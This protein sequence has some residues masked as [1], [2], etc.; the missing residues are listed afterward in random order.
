MTNLSTVS[1]SEAAIAP[2]TLRVLIV[3]DNRDAAD[4]LGMF[5]RVKGHDVRIAY[6]GVEGVG[7]ALAFKPQIVL[8]DIGLPKLFGYDVAREL[9]EKF[10]HSVLIV[11]ITGYGQEEDRRRSKEAGFDYH[12]TKPVDLLELERLFVAH[13]P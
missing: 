1:E 13:R 8:H 5:L 9:R 3:D 2:E 11:A 10:G 4:T 7:A 12:F 6:D